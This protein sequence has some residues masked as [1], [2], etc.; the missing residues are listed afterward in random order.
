VWAIFGGD[1][2]STTLRFSRREK[3]PHNDRA[4][5]LTY[6]PWRKK[7]VNKRISKRIVRP[8]MNLIGP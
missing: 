1:Y 3:R 5:R 8:S 4:A 7:I 6:W 2:C